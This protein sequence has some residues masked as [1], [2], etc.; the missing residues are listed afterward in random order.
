MPH[1]D[2][3][4]L[5]NKVCVV[6]GGASGIGFE[7]AMLLGEVGAKVILLDIN[8]KNGKKQPAT[9]KAKDMLQSM[10]SVM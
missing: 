3:F 1:L 6:T 7:T 2:Y 9:L 5:N 4:Q 8:E 10:S